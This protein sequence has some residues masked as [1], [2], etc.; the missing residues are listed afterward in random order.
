MVLMRCWNPTSPAFIARTLGIQKPTVSSWI[1][2]LHMSC[3]LKSRW[4]I[5][6]PYQK[7]VPGLTFKKIIT[8][9]I[10][11]QSGGDKVCGP[12]QIDQT[13]YKKRMVRLIENISSQ[14]VSAQIKI[15]VMQ[16]AG[17][18][19]PKVNMGCR[20]KRIPSLFDSGSQVTLIHQS[21]FEWEIL[22]HIGP[23]GGEKA[24]VHQLFQLT[25][26]NHGRFP[27]SMYEE[28]DLDFWGIVGPKVGV[29]ITQE[30][31]ELL[32]ECHETELPGIIG[33]NLIRLDY[34]V[35]VQKYGSISLENF[36]CPMGISPLLFSQ[37]C[38]FHHS[39]AGGIQLD[40]ITINAIGQQQ[41]S[42]K[43]PTIYHE[44]RMAIE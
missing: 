15:E 6:R 20:R 23:S 44:W 26:A 2:K 7:R 27:M 4:H 39:K 5:T 9:Q 8:P 28:L 34:L 30:P 17:A 40:S 25:A 22:P 31:N 19:C 3:K 14:Q 1:I 43:C 42:K 18:T 13:N 21:F 10:L 35:F 11:D 41:L 38:V 16:R 29:L 24:E 33:W 12:D 36:D 37:L 32:D